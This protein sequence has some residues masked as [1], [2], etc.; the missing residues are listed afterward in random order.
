MYSLTENIDP[1]VMF[2]SSSHSSHSKYSNIFWFISSSLKGSDTSKVVLYITPTTLWTTW[3]H[4]Y[5]III[6]FV[7][8]NFGLFIVICLHFLGYGYFGDTRSSKT[9]NKLLGWKHGGWLYIQASSSL[10]TVRSS[11]AS[12][13]KFLFVLFFQNVFANNLF[14]LFNES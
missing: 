8:G 11:L 1:Y 2:L 6:D 4:F 7:D 13:G 9:T 10:A 14:F 3:C 5:D 12:P